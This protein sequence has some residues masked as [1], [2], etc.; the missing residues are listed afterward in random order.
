MMLR[1][2]G[3]EYRTYMGRT[4]RIIPHLY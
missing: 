1:T 2:F 3:E 4:K